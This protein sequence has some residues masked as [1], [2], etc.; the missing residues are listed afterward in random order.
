MSRFLLRQLA[1]AAVITALETYLWELAA[2][3]WENDAE[4]LDRVMAHQPHHRQR[5]ENLGG[6]NA[7]NRETLR[8]EIFKAKVWH[9]WEKN[10]PFLSRVVNVPLPPHAA[11]VEPTRIRHDIAHRGGKDLEHNPVN[12]SAEDLEALMGH[13]L[14]FAEKLQASVDGRGVPPV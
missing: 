6:D 5:L 11:L 12:I 10:E 8:Q 9:R 2:Y 1:Y 3:W 4:A 7:E 13:V 14:T